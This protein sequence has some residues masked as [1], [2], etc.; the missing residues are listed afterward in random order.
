M[1]LEGSAANAEGVIR[2]L[3]D[4]GA[5]ANFVS[6][7]L[8][9][10]LGTA[11]ESTSASL[12]LADSTEAKLIG[13]TTIKLKIQQQFS[14]VLHCYV[15]E[16]CDEFDIILG[17]AFLVAHKAVLDYGRRCISITRDGRKYCLKAINAQ[18]CEPQVTDDDGVEKAR[19]SKL[20]L[21]YAQA[22]RCVKNGCESF[23]VLV[24]TGNAESDVS[25]DDPAVIDDDDD[26]ECTD[27]NNNRAAVPELAEHLDASL[28]HYADVFAEPSGLPPDR[29]VEHVVPLVPGAQPEF[30]RMYR[31]APAELKEVNRQVTDL[32]KRQLIEPSTSPWGS[33]ILF[34]KKKDGSLRMVV[35]Y[36]ALN[37]LT[38]KNRYPLPR[39]DDLFDKLHGAKYFSS[40]DAA[41]GFHQILLK[42]EDR[43]KTAFR[44]PFGHY[45][46][47]VLPFGL[48][49]APATF[50]AVMNRLFNQPKFNA[51]GTENPMHILSEF[52]LV[53]IDDI[54]IFRK[55]C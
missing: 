28:Q 8:L 44:T 46:F 49:N 42:E 20:I 16:L 48:T 51:D 15:T 45:Q 22:A 35:D 18:Q 7:R 21:N 41:S 9:A 30:K 10:T 55:N 13:E 47:R 12:R 4:S 2:T 38:V 19:T 36:R 32:L 6:P 52:V 14:A 3:I 33:P 11:W 26:D 5:T 24:N 54:L 40:L 31:L 39:I 29:G 25:V 1:L 34:V 37:K 27:G 50:Q 43:P 53:F 17:N 23:F